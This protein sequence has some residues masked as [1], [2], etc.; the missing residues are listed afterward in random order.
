[1]LGV[2][3]F[4]YARLGNNLLQ[5]GSFNIPLLSLQNTLSPFFI[6]FLEYLNRVRNFIDIRTSRLE[7]LWLCFHSLLCF[8]FRI[9]L[10]FY[11]NILNSFLS[12]CLHYLFLILP[13]PK[14]LQLFF[15]VFFQVG[16]H[17]PKKIF[18]QP[19]E[20]T[21]QEVHSFGFDYWQFLVIHN[22]DN[23]GNVRF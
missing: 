5:Q 23:W 22:M 16:K 14:A 3:N 18:A 8:S 17:R 4:G 20:P 7:W 12:I 10:H 11:G 13:L 9:S 2:C 6:K 21:F 1:M 15:H 19:L